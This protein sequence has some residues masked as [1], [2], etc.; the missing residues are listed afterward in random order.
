MLCVYDGH[1]E[2]YGALGIASHESVA[3]SRFLTNLYLHAVHYRTF[4]LL[5]D[6]YGTLGRLF[7]GPISAEP[8][9]TMMERL[10]RGQYIGYGSETYAM[11]LANFKDNL[12]D[13]KSICSQHN[14]YL[15][16]GSQVS[17]LRDRP[18]FISQDSR[19]WS[20]DQKL[21]FQLMFNQGISYLLNDQPD[22]ALIA[23]DKAMLLDSL[24]ADVRFQRGRSLDSLKRRQEAR[25]EYEKARDYDM[26]RFRASSD[27]N[28]AIQ[29]IQDGHRVFF[30]DMERKFRSS[31]PDSLI[32]CNLILEHLHPNDRGYFLMAKEFTWPMHLHNI[33][34][35]EE[36]WNHRDHL[37]DDKLW[38]ERPLTELDTMC[39]T[40]RTKLLTSGWPFR[41]DTKE[42]P[43]P[44]PEDTLGTIAAEMVEG[45][46]TWEEGHVAAATFLERRGQFEKAEREYK[47]LINQVPLNISAYLFLGRLWLTHGRNEEAAAVLLASTTIEQTLFANR[48]LGILA[49]EPKDAIPFFQHAL[50]LSLATPEKTDA[51]YLLADAY[52]RDGKADRAIDQLQQ[53]LSLAP[54]FVPARRLLQQIN[55]KRQ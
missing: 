45:T 7:H 6:L 10:A 42:L 3:A 23:F 54:D 26:L 12:N 52:N 49:F 9:G 14:I 55:T 20:Q 43:W 36:T 38:S 16:L 32:G 11:A 34:A 24:R 37:D 18:P 29:E 44:P 33:I 2:F 46:I 47:A 31:S 53:V 41:P 1:N 30:V 5:R 40:R 51:G 13:L 39:A 17:N 50:A 21:Q 8:S 27:F 19:S 22:S 28:N 4:I 48:A 35:D 15:L 25:V